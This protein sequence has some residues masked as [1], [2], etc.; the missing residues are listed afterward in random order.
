IDQKRKNKNI[1]IIS[2]CDPLWLLEG[3]AKGLSDKELLKIKLAKKDIKTGEWRRLEYKNLPLDREGRVDFHRPYVDGIKFHCSKCGE[4]MVRVPEVCDVW[5]DSG[6]MPF[7]QVHWPFVSK[8]SKPALFPADYISEAIDQT[9]GWFYTLLAVST[10]LG[11]GSPY[12]NV[13]SQG[14][15]LDEKGEK[16]SKSRGN[17]VDPWY[18]I[19]KYGVDAVRWYF[20]TVNQPGD[21]KLFAEKDIDQTLKKFILILW[22]CFTFYQTYKKTKNKKQKTKNILDKWVVS[23][24]NELILGVTEKL[25]KYDVTGAARLIEDFVIN[26]LSLWYIRRSRKRFEEAAGTLAL[27]LQTVSKLT[28]PFIPFLSDEIYKCLLPGSKQSVH[29]ESWPKADK[30]LINKKLN[31]KMAKVR[32]IVTLA[33]A[34]RAKA[35]IKVRQPLASLRIPEKMDK[36]LSELIKEEVNVKKIISGGILILDTKITPELKE[37]G[38]VREVVRQINEMR[39]EVG[40]T[41]KDKISVRYFGTPGLNKILEKNKK[42]ILAEIKAK[43]FKLG[44]EPLFAP[45]SPMLRRA[46]NASE[47]KE[48]KIDQ[49]NIW[50]A[51]RKI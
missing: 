5:F 27:V 40:L 19:E 14:H 37:E 36:E 34:E 48:V 6:C 25:D 23:R 16:M 38:I 24:L 45:P 21:S 46:S 30:K 3:A 29:L 22:N 42:N 47:G 51:I 49:Q 11:Q 41:P 39:K 33:L 7:A 26:D 43:N 12:K 10:L 44:K 2:H 28:A 15:V 13:I 50:L 35:G 17:V 9:R 8:T 4:I 20:Y 18:I 1:L 32:E 31:Q